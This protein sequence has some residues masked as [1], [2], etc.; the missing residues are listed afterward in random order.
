M[1]KFKLFISEYLFYFK[2]IIF[3]FNVFCFA[4]RLKILNSE[5]TISKII[6]EKLSVTRFGDG[7]FYILNQRDTFFQNRNSELSDKLKE[8]LESDNKNCLICI[9]KSLQK[10]SNLRIQSK[11]YALNF[12]Y[13]NFQNLVR[14][15]LSLNKIYGD[16][17]FTRF[18]MM[19]KN[20]KNL[21]PYIQ[22]L[23]KIWEKRN[24]LIVEGRNTR[25]GIGN[26]LFDNAKSI[27][28]ILC[29][30]INAFDKYEKILKEVKK[31]V[32]QEDLVLVSLGMTAT[33][34]SYDFSKSGFQAI[35]IG[36][37]DIEYEWMK[38]GATE[39]V[40]VGNKQMKEVD[41]KDKKIEE[42]K[43]PK[44]LSQVIIKID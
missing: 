17:L 29:P 30:D 43:D 36:H 7:E 32:K 1:I 33:A 4:R 12:L 6:S 28:R 42:C 25:L 26:D 5:T 3:K 41:K 21:E 44:Y 22:L 40:E 15:Y 34:L 24:L 38:M 9:P 8:V 23:K 10:F 18:Y 11:L 14:P 20:K 37:I 13:N 35:D 27:R 16:S 19:R 2:L 31:H 39:K